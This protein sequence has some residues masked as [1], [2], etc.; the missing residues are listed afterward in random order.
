MSQSRESFEKRWKKHAERLIGISA[1]K[2]GA[3]E[4][5]HQQIIE[6]ACK[7]FFQKGFHPTSMREI[8]KSAGMSM[9]QMYHYI[10]SKD[11]VLFLIHKHMQTLWY[12]RLTDAKIEEAEDPSRKLELVVK[13]SLSFLIENKNLIQ[14]VY[15]ESKYLSKA[16]LRVVLEMDNRNVL[17]YWCRLVKD[18]SEQQKIPVDVDLTGNLIAY[19]NAFLSFRRWNL[20]NRSIEESKEFV[21]D[22]IFKGIGIARPE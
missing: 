3:I 17:E 22:F 14:F 16:H 20:K 15:T 19:V 21:I 10:S 4:G 12:Q 7:I 11:D 18:A 6:G 2:T 13:E 1:K 9:G 5:K 8:A